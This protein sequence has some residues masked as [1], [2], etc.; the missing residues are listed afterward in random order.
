MPGGRWSTARAKA[1]RI[2]RRVAGATRWGDELRGVRENVAAL[3]DAL[4]D[5]DRRI[6]LRDA[7]AVDETDEPTTSCVCTQARCSSASFVSWCARLGIGP[8]LHRWHW[9]KVHIARSLHAGG[10]IGPGRRGVG[11][12]VGGEPLVAWFA[13]QG[14][15]I[16]A[17]DLATSDE[18]SE[19]WSIGPAAAGAGTMAALERPD[20]CPTEEFRQRVSV[21]AVDMNDVPTDL[22]G[23]DFCWS[24]CALEHLGTLEH[25]LDFVVRSLDC[26]RPGG[27]AVHT[28]EFNI[29]SDDDTLVDG[30][31]V[32]YRARDL[33]ALVER[34]SSA[35]HH[36]ATLDLAPGEGPFDRYAM[37][38]DVVGTPT[39]K[40][41]IDR[42][43]S[44]TVAL[45]IRRRDEP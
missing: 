38:S 36:V 13:A 19:Q 6:A 39:V 41:R 7:T 33:H 40:V 1:R 35:G 23:F 32:L 18:R 45:V 21:R 42:F 17:T 37:P 27:I 20:V 34:L 9:E 26:L 22:V 16:V 30:D 29:T 14:C 44:T 11:F 25:G 10:V 3:A 12:G 28:T 2:R 31:V 5:V 24:A 43:V 15:H 8:E 4:A